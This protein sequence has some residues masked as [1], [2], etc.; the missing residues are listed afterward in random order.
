MRISLAFILLAFASIAAAWKVILYE[1]PNF[2]A[3]NHPSKLL[4]K[5]VGTTKIGRF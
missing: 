1:H 3:G 2:N 5:L 4:S